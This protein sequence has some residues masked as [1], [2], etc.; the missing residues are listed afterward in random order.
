MGQLDYAMLDKLF[1]HPARS[2]GAARRYSPSE[3]VGTESRWIMGDPEMKFVSTRYAE[4]ENTRMRTNICRLTRL[5]N[6]H[7]KKVENH[8]HT[9]AL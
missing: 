8:V 2:P 3:V 5:T 1:A 4:S 9:M 6:G 7:S